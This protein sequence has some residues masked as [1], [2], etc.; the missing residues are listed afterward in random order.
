MAGQK[1]QASAWLERAAA[2]RDRGLPYVKTGAQLASLRGDPRYAALLR[3]MKR[4]NSGAA[5]PLP[6]GW[7]PESRRLWRAGVDH[8]RRLGGRPWQ[9]NSN[10][11]K[12]ELDQAVVGQLQSCEVLNW[13]V[14]SGSSAVAIVV[15]YK[16]GT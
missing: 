15:S 12:R 16:L 13:L 2:Q 7:L 8:E 3:K 1:D 10:D 4:R 9:R 11:W 6:R 14:L 5:Y